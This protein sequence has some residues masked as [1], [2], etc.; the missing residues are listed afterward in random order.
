M[1][2]YLLS[3]APV[4]L[5]LLLLVAEL[6]RAHKY[7][8]LWILLLFT[9]STAFYLVSASKL[10]VTGEKLFPYAALIVRPL[11]VCI[12]PTF[13]LV[14]H[15]SVSR[16]L[17]R[18]MCVLMY[19]PAVLLVLI[20]P[21]TGVTGIDSSLRY[22]VSYHASVHFTVY[23]HTIG[24]SPVELILMCQG[25]WA[26]MKAWKD[27]TEDGDKELR[28]DTANSIIRYFGNLGF[29][30]STFSAVGCLNWMEHKDYALLAFCFLSYSLA[31]GLH[32]IRKNIVEHRYIEEEEEIF[33]DLID[34]AVAGA[35]TVD[36]EEI[37]EEEQKTPIPPIDFAVVPEIP[38][39][40]VQE[41]PAK[42]AGAEPVKAELSQKEVLA[43]ELRAL[44]EEEKIYLQA[45]IRIDEVA[46]MLGTN[47]TYLA[48]MMKQIYGHSFAEYMNLCRVESA[49]LDMLL[50]QDTPIETIALNNGFN[51]SNTFNKVF[52]QFIGT[53]PAA[54]KKET[55]G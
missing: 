25:V 13:M 45:G 49:K 24:W 53:S 23:E 48:K 39:E 41:E 19:M 40:E 28:T 29:A 22:G 16:P 47:R 44:V 5:F 55:L 12:L 8:A 2:V 15:A 20:D 11:A 4:M 18:R 6:L 52:N 31:G 32:T 37:I 54:W 46:L 43:L 36:E 51:S 27:Y 42:A 10:I 30:L 9:V 21:V 3:M 26:M 7:K 35:E 38:R 14:S 1:T 50:H 33:A 34:K 17:P